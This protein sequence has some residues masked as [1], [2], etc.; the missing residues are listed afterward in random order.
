MQVL[1][2]AIPG[3]HY[4]H[5]HG[6]FLSF[7]RDGDGKLAAIGVLPEHQGEG[8]GTALLEKAKT[9][10]RSAAKEDGGELKSLVIGSSWPRVWPQLLLDWPQEVRDFFGHRGKLQFH[11]MILRN[12]Y[13]LQASINPRK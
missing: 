4:I 10:L 5:D 13:G 12:A 1:L 9:V 7:L 11:Q 3:H 6:F 2:Y 8:L